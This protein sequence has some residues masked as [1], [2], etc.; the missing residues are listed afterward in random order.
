ME[1]AMEIARN[2]KSEVIG[3]SPEFVGHLKM[4]LETSAE[5]VKISVTSYSE[6]PVVNMIQTAVHSGPRFKILTAV[7][8]MHE[9]DLVH[10]VDDNVEKSFASR[11]MVAQR[12]HSLM[13]TT[14]TTIITTII[15]T[16][17]NAG[18]CTGKRCH[19]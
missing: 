9:K 10:L 8:G 17:T 13:I 14:I 16:V 7:S 2:V 4:F 3:F 18:T 15:I 6:D 5:T 1:I 19:G 12:L 11:D